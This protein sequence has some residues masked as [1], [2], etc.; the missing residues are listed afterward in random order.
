[1]RHERHPAERA[2]MNTRKQIS[3]QR[4]QFIVI[5]QCSV[6]TFSFTYR[7]VGSWHITV[8]FFVGN[9]DCLL[10]KRRNSIFSNFSNKCYQSIRSEISSQIGM[11]HV[12]VKKKWSYDLFL[13]ASRYVTFKQF[14]K[15]RKSMFEAET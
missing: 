12:K 3:N 1:M 15:I 10:R 4:N 9:I 6:V 5:K 11:P 13:I 2:F 7:L 8:H 14:L